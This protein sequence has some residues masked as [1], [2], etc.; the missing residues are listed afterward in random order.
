MA[1]AAP[2][3]TIPTLSRIPGL[4]HGFVLRTPGIDVDS[5]DKAA[6]L[7]RLKPSHEAARAEIGM[8]DWPLV[9]SDQVHGAEIHAVTRENLE[10]SAV[11][12]IP[13]ADGLVTNLP[14][15]AL[16]VH[17]A[18][19]GAVWI[20]DP[21]IRAIGLVHSGKNGTQLKIAARAIQILAER[22]DS[23]PERLIVALSPCIRPPAYEVA[24][25]AEIRA[26]ILEAGVP[27]S[28]FHDSGV[29][30]STDLTRFYS[31]RMEKGHTGRML[32]LLG[33]ESDSTT[34]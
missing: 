9:T 23:S 19:C 25:A 34:P 2:I 20:V 8:G 15:V 14:G 4:H 29:C 11:G 13:D 3:E 1:T 17:V 33:W 30:T 32:A 18:D 24:F 21:E 10:I 6:V 12:P 22:Y 28:Q 7:E 27:E 5:P 16:G 31:Y 26:Q